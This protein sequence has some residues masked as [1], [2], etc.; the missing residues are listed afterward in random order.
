MEMTDV[1]CNSDAAMALFAFFDVLAKYVLQSNRLS[2]ISEKKAIDDEI[3][4][5]K[6]IL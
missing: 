1:C 2:L 4:M 3:K 6:F 5:A